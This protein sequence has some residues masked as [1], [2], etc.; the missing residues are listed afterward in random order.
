MQVDAELQ[1]FGRDVSSLL[2]HKAGKPHYVN[3]GIL[4]R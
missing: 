3:D 2:L 4:S 1:S